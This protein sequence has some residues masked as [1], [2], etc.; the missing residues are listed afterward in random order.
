[1]YPSEASLGGARAFTAIKWREIRITKGE[2]LFEGPNGQARLLDL[3]EGRRQLITYHFIFDPSWDD[4]CPS[5]TYL[6]SDLPSRLAS[7]HASETSLV[8]VSSAPLPK[9]DSYKTRK[10]WTVPWVSSYG[11]DFNY[12]FWVTYDEGEHLY[13][14]VGYLSASRRTSL[15]VSASR[16]WV[17]R[18]HAWIA[19]LL[20]LA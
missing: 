16:A 14:W 12:D 18:I 11:S 2:Y 3:F 5:C 15:P 7:L 8:L 4:G 1:M 17:L 19:A 9:L 10:N 6:V 13:C 20:G